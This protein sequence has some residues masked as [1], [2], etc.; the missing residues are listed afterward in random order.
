MKKLNESILAN[1]NER[2]FPGAEQQYFCRD[3]GLA[4]EADEIT[5]EEE[6]GNNDG[7]VE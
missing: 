6:G 1:L 5:S 3:C 7:Y 2:Y 4:F